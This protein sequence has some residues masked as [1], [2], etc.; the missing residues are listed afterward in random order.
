MNILIEARF[1]TFQGVDK[2]FRRSL[3]H[4]PRRGDLVTTPEGKTL[5]VSE[6]R[7]NYDTVTPP[8]DV[9]ILLETKGSYSVAI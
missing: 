2:D 4:V 3:I 9:N 5:V 7:W 1:N 8:I 6:V